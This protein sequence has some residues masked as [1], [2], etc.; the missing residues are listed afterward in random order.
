M[1]ELSIWELAGLNPAGNK[2]YLEVGQGMSKTQRVASEKQ[3]Y[4]ITDRGTWLSKMDSLD[5]E[6]VFEGDPP[7]FNQYGVMAVNPEKYGF[8]KYKEAMILIKW[9]TSPEGQKAIADYRTVLGDQLFKPNYKGD[10][11]NAR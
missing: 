8:V 1:K 3:A 4:T 2:W 5:L 6:I 11:G 7:L 9:I 10:N